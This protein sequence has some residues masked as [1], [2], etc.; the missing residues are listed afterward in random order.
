M[1]LGILVVASGCRKLQDVID[2]KRLGYGNW[3]MVLILAVVN[4]VMGAALI[5]NSLDAAL[6]FL[7]L[8]GAGL[9]F[10]GVTDCV[11]CFYLAK[12][13]YFDDLNAVDSTFAEVVDQDGEKD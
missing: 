8:M 11:T 5:V 4:V 7:Q 1:I 6:F 2:M 9:I 3:M 12:R 13:A 10:S